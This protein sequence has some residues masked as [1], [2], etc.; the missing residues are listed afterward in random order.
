MILL[1]PV[2]SGGVEEKTVPHASY[3]Y[4]VYDSVLYL[5]AT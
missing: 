2:S 3:D 5:G 1:S 4:S